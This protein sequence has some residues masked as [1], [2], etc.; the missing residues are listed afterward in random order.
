MVYLFQLANFDMLC[1]AQMLRDQHPGSLLYA[2]IYST[3]AKK[4][5]QKCINNI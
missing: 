5:I 4:L 3:S 2:I 1:R